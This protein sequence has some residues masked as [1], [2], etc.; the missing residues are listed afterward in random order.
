MTAPV[1]ASDYVPF[2]TVAVRSYGRLPQVLRELCPLVLKQSY[3]RF[4][5]LIVEQSGEATRAEFQVDLDALREDP[6]VRLLEYGGLGPARARNEAWKHARGE[7]LIF[8]DDDDLPV[9]DEWIALHVQNF[10]DSKCV[11]ISGRHVGEI[12][13]D[14]RPFDTW[15]ARRACLRYTF[16]K[17]PRGYMRHGRRVVGV[18]QVAGTNSSIRVEAIKRAGGWD[19]IDDHDEDSFA[20]RFMRVKNDGEY[21]A[22]DPNPQIVRRLDVAGGVGRRQGSVARLLRSELE[23]SHLVIARYYPGRFYGA[24]PAYL[25]LALKRAYSGA[26]RGDA[27]PDFLTAMRELARSTVPELRAVW[28]KRRAQVK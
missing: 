21:F 25:A 26:R 18:T 5:L 17:M 15:N 6:R 2:V 9:G 14:P 4:E 27:P 8:I 24:Y 13:E 3:P 22:Y 11:A 16:L 10:R 28:Q 1:A 20:F 19:L 23:Y 7:I 12:G